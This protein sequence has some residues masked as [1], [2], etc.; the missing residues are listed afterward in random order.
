MKDV[1]SKADRFSVDFPPDIG[2]IILSDIK[3]KTHK[4]KF[5]LVVEPLR[6][7]AGEPCEPLRK[8]KKHQLKKRM[9]K[10]IKH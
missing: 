10:N 4:K 6:D 2:K 7:W 9:K 8:K 1:L 5:F 3:G